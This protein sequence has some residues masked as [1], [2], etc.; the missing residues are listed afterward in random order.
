VSD[1]AQVKT[2]DGHP[3]MFLRFSGPD[4]YVVEIDGEARTITTMNGDVCRRILPA[5]KRNRLIPKS[6]LDRLD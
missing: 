1:I 3:A 5:A 4:K 6:N 2:L